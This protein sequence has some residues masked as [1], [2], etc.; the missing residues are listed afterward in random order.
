MRTSREE[1]T[2]EQEEQPPREADGHRGKDRIHRGHH[3]QGPAEQGGHRPGD[4]R[5]HHEGRAGDR[6]HRQ[7]PGR[8]PALRLQQD[9]GHHRQR[10]RQS[11]VR[12]RNQDLRIR[13]GKAGLP[14][15]RNGHRGARRARG[16]GRDLRAE[17]ER[18]RRAALPHPEVH[19]RHPA[20]PAERHALRAD[21]PQV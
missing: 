10:H 4:P 11:P 5:E 13:A 12:H 16:A 14:R 9:R 19:G 6:L 1:A 8:G 21:G 17:Q 7:L 15:H 18:G 3:L 2:D 20:A